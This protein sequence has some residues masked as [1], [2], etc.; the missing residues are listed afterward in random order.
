MINSMN[1]DEFVAKLKELV[2]VAD[3]HYRYYRQR[4]RKYKRIDY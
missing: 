4:A 3:W 1:H 2:C